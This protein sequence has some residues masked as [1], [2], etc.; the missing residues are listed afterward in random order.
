V[1]QVL[2]EVV[3]C[4]VVFQFV[5]ESS[6]GDN[7]GRVPSY[8]DKLNSWVCMEK[9]FIVLCLQHGLVSRAQALCF[10]D[11][12]L[13]ICDLHVKGRFPVCVLVIFGPAFPYHVELPDKKCGSGSWHVAFS[14]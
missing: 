4:T 2:L 3:A 5:P 13:C 14:R 11:P 7:G 1:L 9:L 12:L 8:Y 6:N 10:L